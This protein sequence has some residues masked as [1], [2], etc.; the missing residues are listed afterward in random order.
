[1][2][3]ETIF[4]VILSEVEESLTVNFCNFKT[5]MGG[6]STARHCVPLCSR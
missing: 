2:N 1:M 4:F 6:L 5:T 3:L